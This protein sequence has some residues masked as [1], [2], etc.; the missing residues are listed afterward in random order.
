MSNETTVRVFVKACIFFF[1]V[2]FP[3]LGIRAGSFLIGLRG[4]GGGVVQ[5]PGEF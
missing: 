5:C 3:R 1:T 2:L 4:V